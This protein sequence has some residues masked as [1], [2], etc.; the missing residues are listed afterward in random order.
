[1]VNSKNS[2]LVRYAYDSLKEQIMTLKL[3]PG[4]VLSDLTLSKQLN[5]SRTP[6]REALNQ[7]FNDGL[8]SVNNKKWIVS[9]ITLDDIKELFQARLAI[10][11]ACAAIMLRNGLSDQLKAELAALLKEQTEN[12][13]KSQDLALDFA[14]HHKIVVSSKNSRLIGFYENLS[15]QISRLYWLTAF[16]DSWQAHTLDEHTH[17]YEAIRNNDI[18]AL[19]ESIAEH[20]KMTEN[21]YVRILNAT[22]FINVLSIP[23]P[24]LAEALNG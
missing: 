7:L 24:I 1:M 10:E 16:D 21:N 13:V 8:V 4:T 15:L 19:Q 9:F 11:G 17:I 12:R 23:N 3:T 20:L 22:P 14:F 2:D 18:A 6:V 5:I